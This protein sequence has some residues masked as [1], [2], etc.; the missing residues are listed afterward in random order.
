MPIGTIF[1]VY[2]RLSSIG[3]PCTINDFLQKGDQQFA[4]G[5]ILYGSSTLLVYGT[6]RHSVNGFTLDNSLGEFYL[7]HPRMQLPVKGKNYTFDYRYLHG[8]D[9]SLQRFLSSCN[10]SENGADGAMSCRNTGCLVADMHRIFLHGGLFMY[11][12]RKQKPRGK[13]RLMYECNPLSFLAELGGG[14]ASDGEKRVLE[15]EPQTVHDR[16][17]FF[18]GSREL[19]ESLAGS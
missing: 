12:S 3:G 9:E 17:P 4:A 2:R 13:L 8:I 15:I 18:I 6:K 19:M 5:Y 1:S 16:T 11:P 14:I 7:T 10:F